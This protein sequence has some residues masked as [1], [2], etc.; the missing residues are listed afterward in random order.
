[1]IVNEIQR[2]LQPPL[3][4]ASLGIITPQI[5]RLELNDCAG[6]GLGDI[7]DAQA[8]AIGREL[9]GKWFAR[10]VAAGLQ[11]FSNED[12]E[13]IAASYL[14]SG[15]DPQKLAEATEMLAS[16]DS[17]TPSKRYAV[18]WGALS[19]VSMAASAYHGYRRNDSVGWA[20]WWGLM[21]AMFPVITPTIAVA[22]G[23]GRR[24]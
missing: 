11:P 23:F 9:A 16:G 12:R 4:G 14:T 18:I 8:A 21:G 6:C 1:M 22:Q 20:L 17:I 2:S 24:K 19:T 5:T 13:K 7:T 10:D 3:R 15:G